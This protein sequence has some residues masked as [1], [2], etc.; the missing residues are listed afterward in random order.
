MFP[1]ILIC[2]FKGNELWAVVGFSNFIGKEKKIQFLV[3]AYKVFFEVGATAFQRDDG[4]QH[5]FKNKILSF[6]VISLK[7]FLMCIHISD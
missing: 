1:Y 5:K 6:F 4:I 7:T 2:F 3:V